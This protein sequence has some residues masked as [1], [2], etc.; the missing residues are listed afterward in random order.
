MSFW[1]VDAGGGPFWHGDQD[2]CVCLFGLLMQLVG[3]FDTAF[4]NGGKGACV[5]VFGLLM[6]VVGLVDM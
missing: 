5:C 1:P 4:W 3:L 2:A 6:Q